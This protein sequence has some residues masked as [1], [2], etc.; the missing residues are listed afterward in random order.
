MKKINFLSLVI[1][2]TQFNT[3]IF[4]QNK[5]LFD[6]TKAEMA[7]NADWII[8]ADVHNVLF[9]STTH[10]PYAS[11]TTTG[12]SNP[13]RFP[14]PTQS[15][16]NASTSENYW[17]GGISYWAVDCAKKGYLVE[18]L[19]FNGSIT[20]GNPSNLQDLSNY[21]TFVVD[22]P[23][24]LFSTAEKT[25]LLNFVSNGGSLFLIS[26]HDV[27]DRNNDG[28][29]SPHIW[30]DFFNT[31]GSAI[32]PFGITFDSAD[33]SQTTSN[34]PNLPTD[35]LLHGTAGNVTQVKY[36]NGT[37]MTL[38]ISANS[39]VK[40][41]VYKTGALN[42]GLLNVM[43]A[44]GTY[45]SG[46]FVA[47]GDSSLPD[48][49]TGDSNDT[50]YDGYIT[51]ANGN[52]QRLIMNSTIWLM[53]TTLNADY[54]INNFSLIIAPNPIENNSLIFSFNL[55]QTDKVNYSISDTLGREIKS[56]STNSFSIGNNNETIDI[57]NLK[58]GIYFL[59][60]KTATKQSIIK[61]IKK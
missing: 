49:G 36:S 54:P 14:T 58:S 11:A 22:E 26:D 30:N 2:L 9:N 29:D 19:P 15:G 53:T 50:L 24:I 32:N 25:A 44:Y 12:D 10:L 28:Y 31:N 20:Y 48:D 17:Q 8:D 56:Y 52:H 35:P 40:G 1:I 55:D 21:K 23:N 6:A 38:N 13:Q 3:S 45:G 46:K 43:C 39:T 57:Q 59:S 34:I 61:F 42:T 18:T 5:I 33:F 41:V 7:G 27:S 51:D 4:A 37:T 60:I 47:I 16:I